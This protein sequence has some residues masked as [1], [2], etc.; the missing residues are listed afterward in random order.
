MKKTKIITFS[1][2]DGDCV[3]VIV[4][5]FSDEFITCALANFFAEKP[6][7]LNNV[8]YSGGGLTTMTYKVAYGNR[9]RKVH[10]SISHLIGKVS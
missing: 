7:P 8:K 6:L 10:V 1:D 2:K 4:K 3:S 5:E 9:I